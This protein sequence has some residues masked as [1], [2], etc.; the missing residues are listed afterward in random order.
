MFDEDYL[1]SLPD[2]AIMSIDALCH[3]FAENNE[4]WQPS[5]FPEYVN[6]ERHNS[7]ISALGT[8]QAL[9]DAN[10]FKYDEVE[11]GD[12][13]EE[14]IRLVSSFFGEVND[15]ITADVAR[16][17]LEQT[18]EKQSARFG[19]VFLY[20]FQYEEIE[21]IQLLIN[22][23]RTFIRDSEDLEDDHK[24]RLL[25]RLEKLQAELHKA[26]S[27]LDRFW[28]LVGD[29]GVVL[30]KLGNDAKPF[31]NRIRELADI[32]FRSQSRAEGLPGDMPPPLLAKEDDSE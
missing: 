5:G 12:D 6:V 3:S 21:R 2:D 25:R 28:G 24:Q 32:D 1:D 4:D 17:T 31:V 7:Y 11:L 14:N 23:L 9:L 30:N 15:A 26:V 19:Q 10:S 27:D 22:E 16:I 18:R 8:L 29:A 20:K 13:R